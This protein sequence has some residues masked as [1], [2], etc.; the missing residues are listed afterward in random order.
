[1][2]ILIIGAGEVGFNLARHLS[3]S[4][5][6][7]I[8]IEASA[9]RCAVLEEAMD[10][11]TLQGSGADPVVLKEAG[12]G[13][14][15]LLVAVTDSDETNM[16]AVLMAST[17][18]PNHAITMARIRDR[19]YISDPQVKAKFNIDVV[20]NPEGVLA[21]KL[22][23]LLSIPGA[24][25]ILQFE[26]G[27]IQVVAY[28][29]RRGGPLDGKTVSAV[30]KAHKDN[31]FV[32]GAI[33]RHGHDFNS[34]EKVIIPTGKDE[35]KVGDLVYFLAHDKAHD[36]LNQWLRP[37][38]NKPK[39]ILIGG[40]GELSIHLADELSKVG[41]TTRLMLPTPAKAAKASQRL[42]KALVLQADCADL[43]VLAT[44]LNEGADVYI[45]ASK[46]EAVNVLTAMVA[47]K[48]G[49]PRTIVITQRFDFIK[50]IKT[51]HDGVV[52]NP[53]ELAAAHVMRCLHQMKVLEVNIFAAEE[54]EALE[55]VPQADSPLVGK[56]LKDAKLPKGTLVGLII[57]E[58]EHIIPKGNVQIKE[59]D[60]LL[61]FSRTGSLRALEK[62]V[63][64]R[65]K[66]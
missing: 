3:Q 24:R 18:L 44:L 15:D 52:L 53:F 2:K 56:Y 36:A 47:R 12:L 20:I 57:R 46:S 29:A 16:M 62:M 66:W 54:A 43:E 65:F 42:S 59:N 38:L 8:T 32:I 11:V 9:N 17:W 4:N 61:F 40:G 1:V 13:N 49:T 14:V 26:N 27:E 33:T 22:I 30:A 23:K 63:A 64:P 19:K 39:S 50:M 31:D 6:E 51:V 60:R 48:M 25:D 10:V 35:I 37:E 7:V 5:R 28:L 41:Y 58:G 45:A 34:A 21:D 55:L